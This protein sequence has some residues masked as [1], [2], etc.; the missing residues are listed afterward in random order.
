MTEK[1]KIE[2]EELNKIHNMDCLEGMK[3]LPDNSIDLV[4][5]DPPY[6]QKIGGGGSIKK[7]YD[8][9]RE[10]L[11]KISSFEP[12]IFLS[13]IKNKLKKMNLYVWTSKTLIPTYIDF[14]IK[15]KYNW[16]ILIYAKNNPVPAFNNNYLSDVEYCL[17]IR[18]KGATFNN[19]L[20]YKNYKKVM[21]DNL[22]N[23]GL[24]HP[25]IKHQWMIDKLINISSSKNDIVLDPYMGSGTTALSCIN[26]ER[27]YIGFEIEKKYV[28][29]AN[30]RINNEKI[31]IKK[32]FNQIK[33]DK[34]Q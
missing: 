26:L 22:N 27:K 5:T 11:K 2:E 29:L 24:G 21:F 13:I 7:K 1:I 34:I 33:N 4:V 6:E 28:D 17:F 12:H 3:K 15:N 20:G 31:K 23:T 25:T 30:K 10:D 18:E 32:W 14:A 16:D 19:G 9:R 8:Y